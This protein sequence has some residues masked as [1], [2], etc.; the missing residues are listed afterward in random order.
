MN[1][2]IVIYTREGD[3]EITDTVKD[4]TKRYHTS[5]QYAWSI[6]FDDVMPMLIMN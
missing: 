1:D 2:P 4:E 6:M 3:I 5:Y